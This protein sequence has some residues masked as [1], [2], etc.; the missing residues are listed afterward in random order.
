MNVFDPLSTYSSPSRRAVER[1]DPK[2]SDPEPGSVI[3][4]APIFSMVSSG[5]RPA[6][7]LGDGALATGS[8]PR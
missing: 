3:A 1:I 8:R 6:L 4:Q 7:L 5:E 2:A